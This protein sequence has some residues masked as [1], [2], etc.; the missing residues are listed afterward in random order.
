MQTISLTT[1]QIE[2]LISIAKH[3]LPNESCAFLLGKD[4]TVVEVLPMRNGDNSP[5]TFSIDPEDI[6]SSYNLAEKKQVDV[7][8][9]FHSHPAKPSPSETDRKFMEINPVIWLIYSTTEGQ[10]NAF[11]YDDEVKQ[12]GIRIVDSMG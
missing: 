7:I 5:I 6:L 4:E 12:V 3:A 1:A 2:E 9:I 8:A 10:L 11:I